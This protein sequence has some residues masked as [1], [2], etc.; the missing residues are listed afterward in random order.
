MSDSYSASEDTDDDAYAANHDAKE[1]IESL[2]RFRPELRRIKANGR[3]T[4]NVHSE[5]RTE[6]NFQAN[7]ELLKLFLP[8]ETVEEYRIENIHLIPLPLQEPADSG[9]INI[10]LD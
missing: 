4:K 2:L 6:E 9:L 8:D 3:S 1:Q 5:A 7:L 10:T